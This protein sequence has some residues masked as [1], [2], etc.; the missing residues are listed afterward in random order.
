MSVAKSR[1]EVRKTGGDPE[2]RMVICS[3]MVRTCVIR[4]AWVSVWSPERDCRICFLYTS[5]AADDLLCADLGGRRTIKKK[6]FLISV[7]HSLSMLHMCSFRAMPPHLIQ[8][9]II[10]LTITLVHLSF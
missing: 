4:R 10:H 5:D 6:T 8:H 9:I 3:V 2:A 1:G 7:S